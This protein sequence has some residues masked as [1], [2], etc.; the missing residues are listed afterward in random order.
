VELLFRKYFWAVNLLFLTLAALLVARVVN[1]F[2][3]SSLAGAPDTNPPASV[4]RPA[5][6]MTTRLDAEGFSRVTGIPLPKAEVTLKEPA[7]GAGQKDDLTSIPLHTS[8]HVRLLGTTVSTNKYWSFAVIED[9]QA[10]TNDTYMVDDRVQG[11]KVLDILDDCTEFSKDD[12]PNGC[13]IVLN[14]GHR[15]YID[16]K[17]GNGPVAAIAA[18]P[19]AANTDPPPSTIDGNGIKAVGDNKYQVQKA[20]LDKTL[21]NLNDVAMQARIVPAFKD[22]VATGFKLFSIR[23]DSI[24]SKIGVQNGDVIRRI[25]GFEIN[26]PDKALEAYAKLKDSSHIEIEIDRNGSTVNKQYDVVQ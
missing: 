15:E 4:V 9:T 18:K 23:P 17:E 5:F 1:V 12:Q 6:A 25:N 16:D 7:L 10:H 13:V 3:E 2:T 8:L 26:S 21:S 24:Y 20:E 19:V 22:G 11:A 14:N